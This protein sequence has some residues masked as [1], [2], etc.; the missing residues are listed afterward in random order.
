M[1]AF[2]LIHNQRTMQKNK[3]IEVLLLT[4]QLFPGI[5]QLKCFQKNR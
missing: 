2:G 4:W 3:G 1:I 5:G